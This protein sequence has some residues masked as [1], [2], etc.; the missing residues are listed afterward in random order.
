MTADVNMDMPKYD[1]IIEQ[2]KVDLIVSRAEIMC[3]RDHEIPDVLQEVVLELLNFKYDPDHAAGAKEQTALTYVIDNHLRNFRRADTR[4]RA[5]V[6]RLGET[7]SE[8]SREEVDERALDVAAALAS[9]TEMEQFICRRL[10]EGKIKTE[11]AAELDCSRHALD[12]VLRRIRKQ[13]REIGLGGWIG[14]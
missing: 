12:R 7:A 3:F 1:G 11:I 14:K 5:H 10:V 8:F 9:L 4:Y 2:W 6:E 13:F